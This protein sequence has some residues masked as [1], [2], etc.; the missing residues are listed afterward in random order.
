MYD[1]GQ[2]IYRNIILCKHEVFHAKIEP[3]ITIP[4]YILN[5]L[6]P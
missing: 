5:S 2:G 1:L 4:S 3:F 6:Y